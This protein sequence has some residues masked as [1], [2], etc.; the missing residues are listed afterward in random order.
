MRHFKPKWI[1]G[2]TVASVDMGRFSDG[3]GG[4]AH[5]PVIE[6]TDGSKILFSTE[7]T[8]V[9]EYG[10]SILYLPPPKPERR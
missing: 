9:G 10:T 8:D 5:T 6:F 3:R 1:V 7:E 4:T 2:K